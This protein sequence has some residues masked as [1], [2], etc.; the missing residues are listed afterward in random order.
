MIAGY[1]ASEAAGGLGAL[2]LGEWVDGELAYR[3]KVGTGFDA[4]TLADLLARLRPIED[5]ELALAGAP[6]DVRWVRPVLLGP[7]RVFQPDL[8]RVGAARG[9]PRAARGG[10]DAPQ[11]A[12]SAQ[13]ADRRRPTSRRSG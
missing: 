10:A 3:G 5:P 12:P 6:K 2:A 4:A 11:A 8:G 9:V 13:A 1:T 7:G